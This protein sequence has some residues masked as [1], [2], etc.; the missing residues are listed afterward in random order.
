MSSSDSTSET[1][2]STSSSSSNA[3]QRL[4]L[5]AGGV[6]GT[7]SSGGTVNITNTSTDGGAFDVVKQSFDTLAHQQGKGL[8]SLLDSFAKII[9]VGKVTLQSG[10]KLAEQNSALAHDALLAYAPSDGA[11]S[12]ADIQKTIMVV[13][14][15]G[16]IAYAVARH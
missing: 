9:D 14:V 7:A 3:D 15:A 1:K 10:S 16:A 6:G 13:A 5:A 8:D 11:K 4:S 2:S 12:G